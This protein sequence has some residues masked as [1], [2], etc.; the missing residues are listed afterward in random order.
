MLQNPKYVVV[1]AANDLYFWGLLVTAVSLSR[2]ASKT[3]GLVICVF[4]GGI[5]EENYA[6]LERRVKAVHPLSE[7]RRIRVDEKLF[8]ECPNFRGNKMAYARLL[9]PALLLDAE[10]VLYCDVDILWKADIVD[11]MDSCSDQDVGLWAVSVHLPESQRK[12]FVENGW[13]CNFERY[14]NSGVMVMNFNRWRRENISQKVLEFISQNPSV[15]LAE[16]NALNV[17]FSNSERLALLERTW[18]VRPYAQEDWPLLKKAR[19][20]HYAACAPWVRSSWIF[21]FGKMSSLWF[22]EVAKMEG[23]SLLRAAIRVLTLRCLL[24]RLLVTACARTP[25]LRQV[26]SWGLATIGIIRR[27]AKAQKSA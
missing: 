23:C 1:L 7:L 8:A 6:L 12:V 18:N 3:V 14:F 17:Y 27:R 19:A 15:G 11:L 16:Q 5:K 21:P 9:A 22:G 10:K 13:P 4:D 2:H 25:I 24:L 20:V 26:Y